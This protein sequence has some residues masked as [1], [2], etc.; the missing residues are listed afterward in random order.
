MLTSPAN[1]RIVFNARLRI[2][3]Q[4]DKHHRS[5]KQAH[6]EFK[7]VDRDAEPLR[8]QAIVQQVLTELDA[9]AAL[10]QGLL[11]PAAR[12]LPG[13]QWGH[14]LIDQALSEHASTHALAQR[15]RSMSPMD[16]R[17][18]P[19]FSLLCVHALRCMRQAEDGLFTLLA[20]ARV[21][22]PA[23]AQ[24]MQSQRETG[25]PSAPHAPLMPALSVAMA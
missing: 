25:L 12:A 15:L 3:R 8:W 11:L 20:A 6:Q 4:L 13:A 23:L 14:A 5:I 18:G 21:D 7:R 16:E 10:Q 19:R 9:H 22:W 17:Y 1:S 24:A 2:F